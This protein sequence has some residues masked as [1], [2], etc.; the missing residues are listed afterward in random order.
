M[1]HKHCNTDMLG[2]LLIY[3]H[4]PSGTARTW[5]RAYISVK[6]LAAV[7]QPINTLHAL[8]VSCTV[9]SHAKYHHSM[10]VYLISNIVGDSCDNLSVLLQI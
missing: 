8:A 10:F 3:P 1:L 7:L 6:P 4:S 9:Y 2:V 5:D